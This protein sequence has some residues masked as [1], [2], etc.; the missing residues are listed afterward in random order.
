[1]NEKP[2]RKNFR[3]RLEH[4]I[5]TLRNDIISRKYKPGD[6]L[7]SEESLSQHFKLSNKSLRKGLEVLVEEGLIEKIPRVGNRVTEAAES[8]RVTL[9]LACRSVIVKQVGLQT[10]LDQF[11]NK[12][13]NID[14]QL[15]NLD[16]QN[17]YK[18]TKSLMET[19]ML[20]VLM[21]NFQEFQEFME[22]DQHHFFAETE[23]NPNIY[24]FLNQAFTIEDKQYAQP[25]TFSPVIL[26]FNKKHLQENGIYEPDSSWDWHVLMQHA[27]KLTEENRRYGFYFNSLSENRWFVFW[28]QKQIKFNRKNGTYEYSREKLKEALTLC[29]DLIYNKQNAP[30][31]VAESENEVLQL[32]S[33]E[34]TSMI[35]TTYFA[36]NML[37]DVNFP[38]DIAPL[39]ALD[40]AE[41]LLLPIGWAINKHSQQL[42]SAK[43]LIDYF[44]SQEA[45]ETIFRRTLSL[46]ALRT[47][48]IGEDDPLERPSRF[49]MYKE[50]MPTFRLF[51]DSG[52]PQSKLKRIRNELKYFW[53]QMEDVD[54]ACERID[55]VLAEE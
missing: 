42:A 33:Q 13:P 22:A 53:F 8:L 46:P 10:L 1:M 50:I 17:Y 3:Q 6:F 39:P 16:Y 38:Y 51:S 25:F 20:D 18:T 24:P 54:Q 9:K 55:K 32:F 47:A 45:Q 48:E 28:L 52:I 34:K 5:E 30:K 21:L 7:P 35:M 27:E 44:T 23:A 49:F 19:G 37:E 31:F 40:T 12:Y 26:C 11:K 14:V 2:S 29:R 41:T 36:I 4:V 43:L 15:I